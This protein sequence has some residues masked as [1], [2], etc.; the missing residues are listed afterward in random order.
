M[1]L[2]AAARRSNLNEALIAFLNGLGDQQFTVHYIDP[3]DYPDVLPTTWREL[4]NRCWLEDTNM[5]F[6]MYKFTPSGYVKALE[7]SGRSKDPQFRAELGKICK[8]L[9]D[10]LKGRTDSAHFY[11]QELVKQSGVSEAFI[12]NRRRL[13]RYVLG[14]ISAHWDGERLI[15]VPHDFGLTP[16]PQADQTSQ[17]A[18]LPVEKARLPKEKPS[19]PDAHTPKRRTDSTRRKFGRRGGRT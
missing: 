15:R 8:V 18:P 5:N 13:I 11:L 6:E 4:T 19:R 3:K 7:V 2:S 9:K 16:T 1:T 17:P 10:S 14:R 12:C